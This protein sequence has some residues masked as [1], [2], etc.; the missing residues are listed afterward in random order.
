MTLLQGSKLSRTIWVR[1]FF[2]D[3][4]SSF[5]ALVMTIS[6]LI[7]F[8]VN[9]YE[10]FIKDKSMLKKLYGELPPRASDEE[11]DS[12]GK[13]AFRACIENRKDF[14]FGYWTFLLIS[15]FVTCCCCLSGCC[16]RR[17]EWW[18][19]RVHS[20]KKF[21]IARRRLNHELDVQRIVALNRITKLIQ[22]LLFTARQRRTVAYSRKYVLQE[23]DILN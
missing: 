1:T 2:L 21:K 10:T 22:K 4:L 7:G 11:D 18:R 12:D 16:Q 9:N 15:S 14:R 5:G 13:A 19:T 17:F 6:A 8:L 23:T 20:Q 3:F